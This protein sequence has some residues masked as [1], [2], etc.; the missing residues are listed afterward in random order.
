MEAT[1]SLTRTAHAIRSVLAR[2]VPWSTNR[3]RLARRLA[4]AGMAAVAAGSILATARVSD[5]ATTAATST[6]YTFNATL[7]AKHEVPR[8]RDAVHATGSLTGKLILA[9]KKS[10][11]TWRLKATGLSGR[12]R[13]AYLALGKPGHRGI[14]ILPLCNRCRATAHGAYIGPYVAKSTFIRPFRGGGMYV[15]V[16]TRLNPEGEIRGQIK[17]VARY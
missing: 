15:N 2:D 9:G 8:P 11:F 13:S 16:T 12:I 14:T 17:A 6:S 10:S 5:A 1:L 3:R 4:A 7:D